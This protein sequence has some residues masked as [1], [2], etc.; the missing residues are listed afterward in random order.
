MG[1][2]NDRPKNLRPFSP[3]LMIAVCR[4]HVTFLER[5]LAF[6]MIVSTFVF[7]EFYFHLY[8]ARARARAR[9]DRASAATRAAGAARPLTHVVKGEAG[10]CRRR[11]HLIFLTCLFLRH[12]ACLY[13]TFFESCIFRQ[14]K[15]IFCDQIL[16]H[17]APRLKSATHMSAIS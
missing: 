7:W 14:G 2:L 17:R 1:E 15:C 8:L 9:V 12:R 4:L 10:G 16:A 11:A 5:K 6:F 3:V 13:M